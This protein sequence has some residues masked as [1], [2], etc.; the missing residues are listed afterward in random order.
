LGCRDRSFDQE[1]DYVLLL[2]DSFAWG[3][4]PLEQTW[5]AI[6]EQLIGIRVL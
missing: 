6:L 2:G 3:Y 1:D 5:G 4:V